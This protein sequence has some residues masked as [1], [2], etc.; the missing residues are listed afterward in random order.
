MSRVNLCKV[1]WKLTAN[2]QIA[3]CI[4][5]ISH[6]NINYIYLPVCNLAQVSCICFPK[7]VVHLGHMIIKAIYPLI[8]Q[9]LLMVKHT[10][11]VCTALDLMP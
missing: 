10:E 9:G 11:L 6:S 5:C 8:K 7:M 2:I 1:S 3:M 4:V